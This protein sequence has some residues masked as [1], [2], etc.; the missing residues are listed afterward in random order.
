VSRGGCGFASDKLRP[1]GNAS[2]R[3]PRRWPN[4]AIY[5]HGIVQGGSEALDAQTPVDL[6]C[7]ATAATSQKPRRYDGR[8]DGVCGQLRLVP[9]RAQGGPRARSSIGITRPRWPRTELHWTPAS[10]ELPPGASGSGSTGKTSSS[11]SPANNLTIKYLEDVGT[12]DIN[13]P[14]EI[15]DK[16]RPPVRRLA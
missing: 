2:P 4:P 15:R 16:R 9:R 8:G 6:R 10:P 12:F 7:C 3:A 11:R 13:D 14:L 1:R 5:D